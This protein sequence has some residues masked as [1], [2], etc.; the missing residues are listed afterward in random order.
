MKKLILFLFPKIYSPKGQMDLRD[1]ILGIGRAGLLSVITAITE[2]TS[3]GELVLNPKSMGLA[4]LGGVVAYIGYALLK[5][6][7]KN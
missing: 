4:F 7:K 6:K 5:G 3:Q 1:G 2:S